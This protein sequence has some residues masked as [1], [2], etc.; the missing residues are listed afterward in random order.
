MKSV[1]GVVVILFTL[2]S[3][4]F[5][6]ESKQ[7]TPLQEMILTEQSFSK[8]AE[9]KNARD[10]FMEFI[11]DDGLL[12]RP[13]AVN[14]KKWMTEHPA[15]QPPAG[16]R[17]LLAWQPAFAGMAA[18]GDL[19]FTTG[20]WEAKADINDAQPAGYGHFV[21]MWKKQSNGSWRF[22]ADLGIQH[23]ESGG[24]L[25]IWEVEDS[26][27]TRKFKSVD[28]ASATKELLQRDQAFSSETQKAGLSHS[29]HSFA[30]TD[31]RLYL[32]DHL[33]YLGRDAS[34]KALESRTGLL[35]YQVLDGDVSR[36]DD[37]GYTHGTY[38]RADQSDP[39]K[40]EKG[41]YLRIWKKQGNT[42]QI[43]LDVTNPYPAQ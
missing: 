19:G 35:K 40:V 13:G 5:A 23:P 17:P 11:A 25:K 42:W 28:V 41:S 12:F 8:T 7:K 31:A 26:A 6:Q 16:K 22:V 10:A 43:V 24:P 36:S 21:T 30:A 1:F 37:L 2:A 3:V 15:P 32:P 9:I 34:V 38:E 29:F 18:A 20:P 39:A 4:S 27:A 33:P 14:G